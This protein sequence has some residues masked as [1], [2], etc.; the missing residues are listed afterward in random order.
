MEQGLLYKVT[1][2]SASVYSSIMGCRNHKR[3][4][5]KTLEQNN[6]KTH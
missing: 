3:I 1:V 6:I 4:L 5:Q 2:I